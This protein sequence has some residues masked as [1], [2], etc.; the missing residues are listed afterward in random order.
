MINHGEDQHHHKE[1]ATANVQE[2]YQY[3]LT[4]GLDET[5]KQLKF[6]SVDPSKA[7]FKK[8]VSGKDDIEMKKL[9][10]EE[11]NDKSYDQDSSRN[12]LFENDDL[13]G[14][15]YGN[16]Q[17]SHNKALQ[18]TNILNHSPMGDSI[19]AYQQVYLQQYAA[20]VD[21][22]YYPNEVPPE[23]MAQI[24]LD[25]IEQ[26]SRKQKLLL[27]CVPGLR[28]K[29]NKQKFIFKV[30][31]LLSIQLLITFTFVLITMTNYT[32]QDFM[33]AN[34]WLFWTSMGVSL[35]TCISLFCFSK[36]ARKF[37][38]NYIALFIFTVFSSYL[39]AS[40][41]IFQE[42]QNVMIAACL[43]MTVFVSLTLL[44]FFTRFELTVLSGLMTISCHVLIILIPMFIVFRE[45]WI[46]I[47]V[48]CGIIV[49]ISIF[50]IY[51][52]QLIAGGKKYQ[53]SYDDY[54]VGALLLYTD[55]VTLFLW[56]LALLGA[57]K[58][59]T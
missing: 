27:N 32:L 57:A 21:Y 9:G 40:I 46:Y 49:I 37:P 13:Y 24:E 55:V 16:D 11:N 26:K 41:C 5:Q 53:L 2:Q 1:E 7:D 47:I 20:N 30:Y 23:V 52:T 29:T 56:L 12:E 43:T 14:A 59:A 28:G 44:T 33:R 25:N 6:D 17:N 58:Q 39:I 15:V 10:G 50:M 48:C 45:K 8:Q 42:A 51:D 31:T 54:I 4:G 18:N 38:L 35:F 22:Q 36:V 19:D 34:R 3:K